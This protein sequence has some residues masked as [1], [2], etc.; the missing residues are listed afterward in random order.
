MDQKVKEE[1]IKQYL[2]GKTAVELSKIFPYHNATISKM[3]KKEG[4]S[5]GG[6]SQKRLD[7]TEQVIKDFTEKRLYCEDLAKKY[8]VDV[9]TIYRILD[10][11]GIKRQSGYHSK[12]NEHY[13]ENISTPNQAY[14]LGFITADGA[15]VDDVLSIEVQAEDSDVLNFAKQEIN[16]FATLTPTRGC[17]RVC[18]GAKQIG[19]D[20][21]KYGV[22]QNKSK[23][24]KNVP[25]DLIPDTLLP[26]YF[27]GLIDGDGSISSDGRVSIYSGSKD[28]IQDVQNILVEKVGVKKLK[29]YQGTTYFVAWGS[30]EDKEKLFNYIYGNLNETF[31]YKRKY[32]RLKNI[33]Q[34]NTEV[35]N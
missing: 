1:I 28:F 9:H 29:I 10:E 6:I 13:F 22:V 25:T 7:I 17:I 21:K 23:I 5:R 8:Q 2:E 16:P 12:C 33:V 14:L 3:L 27:R 35:T 32:Q 31:Y 19:L 4:V 24:L 34:A 11:A 30:K 15:I 20:L 26:Y 18:F